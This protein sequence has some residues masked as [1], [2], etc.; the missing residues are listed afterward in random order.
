[1]ENDYFASPGTNPSIASIRF[2]IFDETGQ[3]ERTWAF[4]DFTHWKSA[5]NRNKTTHQKENDHENH[6]KDDGEEEEESYYSIR[7]NYTTLPNTNLMVAE[8]SRGLNPGYQRSTVFPV[9][10]FDHAKNSG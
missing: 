8:I 1:V 10:I 5:D 2:E 4:L 9:W 6:R 3:S 7:M